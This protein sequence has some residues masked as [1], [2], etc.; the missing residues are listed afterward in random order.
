MSYTLRG[1]LE[2]RLAAALLPLLA[3]CV[4]AIALP[5]WW[6]VLLV[7]LMVGLG[8]LLDVTLFDAIEYQPG[9]F[10]LP[11]GLVE[12][13]ILMTFVRVL[14]IHVALGAALGIFVGAWL[15]SQVL[16]HG[17]FPMLSLSYAEDG[18]ALG[19]AGVTSIGLVVVA[20]GAAGAIY[21]S[22]VPPTVRLA[23]GVHQGPLVITRSQTLVG[24]RGAIV[25]GGI[26][27][28]ASHVVVR[29]ISV[30]GG[31][32]G[33]VVEGG[34]HGTHHVLLDR[35][36][37]VGAQIDGIHVRRSRVTIR[38]C[39]V[40][41]TA[42][43]TQGIDI[44][45]SADMG[46]SVV[47]GC[48]VT[49]GREGIVVDSAMAMISHNQVTATNMR[50]INM[51]EMSMGMIEHNQVAGALGVGI[52]CGDQSECMIERNHVSGTRA[53][54][55]SGDRAQ[56]GFGIESHYKSIAE[57]DDNDLVGNAQPI[58]VFAGGEVRHER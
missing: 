41:S 29:D 51:N 36:K 2:S 57:L 28:R 9:W 48:T 50:A 44:S 16:A 8:L 45:F 42:G 30:V 54:H 55:P 12:L 43:F 23:A 6:P 27:I 26:V 10:A 25:R 19:R 31:E 4:V 15:V 1:R 14:H 53:D 46:M 22:K 3:A 7:A 56:M 5:A 18:G 37:V 40:D 58:G 17:G 33:I 20:L 34:D 21:W 49:G 38:D 11:L 47:D 13:A 24:D 39:V 52:F 32:N 35:V